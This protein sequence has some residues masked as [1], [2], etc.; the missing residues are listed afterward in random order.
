MERGV[1]DYGSFCGFWFIKEKWI[2]G[3]GIIKVK[4]GGL[5][6]GGIILDDK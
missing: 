6:K 1:V 4:R 2:L 3:E 5:V